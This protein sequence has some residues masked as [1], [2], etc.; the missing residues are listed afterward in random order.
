VAGLVRARDWPARRAPCQVGELDPGA[1]RG[2]LVHCRAGCGGAQPVG[3]RDRCV[4]KAVQD[5][6]F[7]YSC[8]APGRGGQVLDRGERDVRPTENPY[9][10]R[11]RC[12]LSHRRSAWRWV[13]AFSRKER[14]GFTCPRLPGALILLYLA[15]ITLPASSAECSKHEFFLSF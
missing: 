11:S 3:Q 15:M 6:R 9:L 14:R 7:G 10:P 2:A 5:I 13:S 8:D 12:I 1:G 4:G